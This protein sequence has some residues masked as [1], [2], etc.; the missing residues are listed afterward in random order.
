MITKIQ[1]ALIPEKYVS[2]SFEYYILIVA[3]VTIKDINMYPMK[4]KKKRYE[5]VW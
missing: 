1:F 3:K 4:K 2:L 5:Y